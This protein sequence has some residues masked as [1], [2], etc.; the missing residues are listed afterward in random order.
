M[1]R[2]PQACAGW[3]EVFLNPEAAE[4]QSV[5]ASLIAGH[6]IV[7]INALASQDECQDLLTTATATIME[8]HGLMMSLATHGRVRMPVLDVFTPKTQLQC[9]VILARAL[10]LVDTEL[11]A[12][13]KELFEGTPLTTLIGNPAFRFADGEPGINVYTEGGLF[14]PHEDRESLTTLTT[15]T[16][17]DQFEGGGTAF[18]ASS[19][20]CLVCKPFIEQL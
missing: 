18:W 15:V 12:V 6:S 13:R 8:T 2:L 14:P 3:H 1:A 4:A 16:G 17:E 11:P 9:D 20:H 7:I 10:A 5:S 19:G